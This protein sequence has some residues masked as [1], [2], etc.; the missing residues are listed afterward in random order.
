MTMTAKQT[1]DKLVESIGLL[2]DDGHSEDETAISN[3]IEIQGEWEEMLIKER[4]TEHA[5]KQ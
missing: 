2:M 4:M 5:G 1:H 3:L